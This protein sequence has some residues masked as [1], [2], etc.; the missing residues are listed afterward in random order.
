MAATNYFNVFNRLVFDN[1][2]AINLLN[3]ANL[4]SLSESVIDNITIPYLVKDGE[5]PEEIAEDYYGSTTFFW[6]IL[7]MNNI[8]NI[9]EDWPKSDNVL[10]EYIKQ[11]YGSIE[12]A[13]TQ[14]HHYEDAAGNVINKDR[15]ISTALTNDITD[16]LDYWDGSETK[17]VTYFEYETNLN[18]QKRVIKL[19]RPEYKSQIF[20]EFQNI[21]S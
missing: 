14:V 12:Y 1:K 4:V 5:R 21:F 9:Y 8:K 10:Y 6:I 18:D 16:G 7:Y 11:K 19:L 20:K 2:L 17:R 13:L 15:I 3:R